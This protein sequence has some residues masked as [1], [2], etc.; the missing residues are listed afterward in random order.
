MAKVDLY[1]DFRELLES[2]NSAKVKYLLLG[3]YAVIHYGY[4]RTTD[5]LDIWIAIAPENAEKL[6]AVLR[7]WG[8][9]SAAK[10]PAEMFLEAGKVFI[11]GREP[12]RVDI[13]T[14]PSGVNFEACYSRRNPVELDGIVV[15]MISLED[16]RA[17]KLASGRNKDLA[18]LDYLPAKTK[19]RASVRVRR[20]GK[21]KRK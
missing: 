7:K 19:R 9:F 6:S 11:F 16:L 17:N 20:S 12:V 14:Q 8:G 1:P 3:G 18:D 4:H 21:K 2:L 10:V 15:P 13:L 5:D